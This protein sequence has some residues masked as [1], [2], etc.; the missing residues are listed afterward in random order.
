MTETT[1]L[2]LSPIFN[3]SVAILIALSVFV[4]GCAFLFSPVMAVILILN[5]TGIALTELI[6]PH[7]ILCFPISCCLFHCGEPSFD[8][9]LNCTISFVRDVSAIG[10]ALSLLFHVT[11]PITM[12]TL[13]IVYI[14]TS[15]AF[16]LKDTMIAA[17]N[18]MLTN[19][20][21]QSTNLNMS[22]SNQ[23]SNNM[24]ASFF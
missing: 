10:L 5:L 15:V 16:A 6:Y 9:R 2:L 3:S 22:P 19:T 24:N 21:Y 23:Y 20:E 14:A 1:K 7:S 17:F 12:P 13:A 8:D 4:P 18:L 11:L